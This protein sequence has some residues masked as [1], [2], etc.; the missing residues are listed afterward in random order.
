[1]TSSVADLYPRSQAAILA[2]QL[3]PSSRTVDYQRAAAMEPPSEFGSW[4]DS[5][6]NFLRS[7][8]ATIHSTGTSL[9]RVLEAARDLRKGATDEARAVELQAQSVT[10]PRMDRPPSWFE[11]NTLSASSSNGGIV[12]GLA[13]VGGLLFLIFMG[14]KSR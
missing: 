14:S 8:E 11:L 13:A 1:M 6:E 4:L 7:G 10:D 2:R 5:L 12:L 9:Q 3:D